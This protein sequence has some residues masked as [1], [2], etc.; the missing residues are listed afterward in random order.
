MR[1]LIIASMNAGKIREYKNAFKSLDINLKSLLDYQDEM[2]IE[3]TGSTFK[4]NAL[5]KAREIYKKYNLPVIADDSGLVV[6]ALKNLLGVKSKRFSVSGTDEDNIA[7]L[8]QKLKNESDRL[9]YF[10]TVICFYVNENDIRFYEGKTSGIIIDEQRGNNGFGYDPIFWL[11]EL[12]K[13]YA[14]LSL[15]EKALV[16]H[17]GKAIKKL[18]EDINDENFSF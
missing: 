18:L 9:A 5:I 15:D 12:N 4:E 17:R 6:N 10:V 1:E 7:L 3:E 14:E 13:T 8:T 2:E 11:E 16:S